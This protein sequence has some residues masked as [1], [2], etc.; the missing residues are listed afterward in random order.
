MILHAI[1]WITLQL[2]IAMGI[3]ERQDG[4]LFCDLSI[5]MFK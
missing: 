1:Q 4:I 3:S 2:T 5:K